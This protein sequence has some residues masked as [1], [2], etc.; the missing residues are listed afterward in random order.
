MKNSIHNNQKNITIQLF[1]IIACIM[2]LLT[3]MRSVVPMDAISNYIDFGGFGV[4]VFF[5]ISGYL[6]FN[7][8]DLANGRVLN[9]YKKRALRILP[10]FYV[11]ILIWAVLRSFV[12]VDMPEDPAG[13]YWLNYVLLIF[14]SYPNSVIE[15]SNVGAVWTIASFIYFYL[16]MP[17]FYKYINSFSKALIAEILFIG[18]NI[19]YYLFSI[20]WFEPLSDLCIFGLGILIY[21]AKNESQESKFTLFGCLLLIIWIINL[22]DVKH[23][24]FISIIMAI[25]IINSNVKNTSIGHIKVLS[26]LFNILDYYSFD[27]YLSHP[28]VLYLVS[29]LGLASNNNLIKAIIIIAGIVVLSVILDKISSIICSIFEKLSVMNRRRLGK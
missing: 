28:I 18:I 10:L 27:I 16:F 22:S 29:K 7:S 6:A 8:A 23:M 25:M 24:L 12:F 1:R 19:A 20:K 21:F 9:Y 11:V 17:L 14:K 5:I 15:W 26:S 13:L 3:H 2:V 4:G